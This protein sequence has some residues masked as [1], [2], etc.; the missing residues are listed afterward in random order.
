MKRL[1]TLLIVFALAFS[2]TGC[3]KTNGKTVFDRTKTLFDMIKA[4]PAAR[5]ELPDG[6]S[7]YVDSEIDSL[8]SFADLD[9][10]AA[11]MEPADNED[12]WLYRIVFNPS[13]KVANADEIVVSI[14]EK[15]V[16]IDIEYYLPPQGVEFESVLQWAESKFDY[17]FN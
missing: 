9:L 10:S 2:I 4:S 16:Q 3:S 11:P 1:F 7:V 12:D 6:S 8:R 15:Y 5:M 17:F 13:E 14:H